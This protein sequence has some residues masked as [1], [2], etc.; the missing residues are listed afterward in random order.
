[1]LEVVFNEILEIRLRMRKKSTL[2]LE[3]FKMLTK[4]HRKGIE[5]LCKLA[6]PEKYTERDSICC[7]EYMLAYY[8]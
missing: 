4:I 1:M 6:G 2:I 8:L 7:T 5:L 3:T